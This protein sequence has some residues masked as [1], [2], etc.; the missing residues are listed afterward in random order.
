[1]Q[2][3][4]M[5]NFTLFPFL[6]KYRNNTI[7]GAEAISYI[8]D[9]CTFSKIHSRTSRRIYRLALL[10]FSPETLS[11]SSKSGSFLNVL[12]MTILRS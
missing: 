1:M 3:M 12:R 7:L 4:L 9:R 11:L 5:G 2:S 10:L 6:L 8:S